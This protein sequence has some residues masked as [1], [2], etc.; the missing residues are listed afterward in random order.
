MTSDPFSDTTNI[1]A[2]SFNIKEKSHPFCPINEVEYDASTI[3]V[4]VLC[5]ILVGLVVVATTVDIVLWALSS[6]IK[7]TTEARSE[8]TKAFP[9]SL[10]RE[11]LSEAT[12]KA[13]IISPTMKDFVLAFS[14][15]NTVPNLLQGQSPSALKALSAIKIFSSITIITFHVQQSIVIFFSATS[16]NTY[17]QH[18]SSSFIFQPVTN[19]TLAV[20]TFF[21]V[22][23]TLSAYLTFKD[24]EKHKRFRFK[25]FYL[26]Q[27]FRLSPLLYLYTLISYKL[28]KLFGQGPVWF[29]FDAHACMST[30]Q[31][32]LLYLANTKFTQTGMMYT[33]MGPTWHIAADMQLFIFS[34]IFI[35]LLY[36]IQYVGLAAVAMAMIAATATVG[37]IIISN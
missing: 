9:R 16:Q 19:V 26:N 24:M 14:L 10:I 5:V 3:A 33:C 17:L 37:Y 31:Y 22:S 7:V 32:V 4:I 21:V 15:Y 1:I 6:N 2:I 12:K 36:R 35:I 27:F 11:N 30:W 25:Y 23:G 13:N 29:P 28:T 8:L 18:V 20:E 34:P